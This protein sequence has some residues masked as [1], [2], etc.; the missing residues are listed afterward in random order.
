MNFTLYLIFFV[1]LV[2]LFAL[3]LTL[4][5]ETQACRH[6]LIKM[7][8]ETKRRKKYS[9]IPNDRAIATFFRLDFFFL[10]FNL[11]LTKFYLFVGAILSVLLLMMNI[12]NKNVHFFSLVL[13]C[14]PL[15]L[16]S[17][18]AFTNWNKRPYKNTQS[19]RHWL[20]VIFLGKMIGVVTEVVNV[21]ASVWLFC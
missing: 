20:C 16:Y 2:C 21:L 17:S 7:R 5:R 8:D 12:C 10:F 1:V 19:T 18:D 13:S 14:L 9:F 6:I 15:F 11:I 3:S 4:T